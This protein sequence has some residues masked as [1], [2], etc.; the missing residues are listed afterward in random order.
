M[1][2][3]KQIN[4]KKHDKN[5]RTTSPELEN[6]S[7][8]SPDNPPF[9]LA[10]FA[11][12]ERERV[13]RRLPIK[14]KWKLPPAVDN[15]ANCTAGG[16]IRF[17][18]D[19]RKLAIR[20]KLLGP[21]G[22]YHMP[23]TGQSGFDCYI[24]APYRQRLCSITHFDQTK[25][26]YECLLFEFADCLMRNITLNFPLYQGVKD[27]KIGLEPGSRVIAPSR[28]VDVRPVVVYGTSITQGG[29]A[30]RPGLAWT[31]ILSRR[32]NRPFV[33]LGFS[34]SGR[35]EPEVARVMAEIENPAMY[36]MDYEANSG[37]LPGMKKTLTKFISIL[38]KA[39]PRVPILL[40]SKIAFAI[41]CHDQQAIKNRLSVR[42][43]ERD[44]VRKLRARGDRNLF[45]CDGSDLLGKDFDEC[46]VD[47]AHPNDLG[48]MRIANALTPVVRSLL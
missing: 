37:G 21:S 24:G 17:H 40:V 33:N 7:W 3:H 16:Q 8:H 45:F 38:R 31:N 48:F 22:M 46:S 2:K 29:C 36:I 42:N 43:F 32:L 13:Y 5:M 34:G 19:S 47:G 23:A 41:E 4:V 10:G 26:E 15:L 6:L 14:P 30:G 1:K 28:Y 12:F 18:T 39:H 9:Q 11:W 20:V 25:S 27:V 35:G 44:T